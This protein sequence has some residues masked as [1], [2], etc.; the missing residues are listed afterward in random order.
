MKEPR[1]DKHVRL[2]QDIPELDLHRGEVGTV[3][4]TWFAP[5][6]AYEVEFEKHPG[7]SVRALLSE[8]QIQEDQA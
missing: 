4:S 1:V 2:K 6:T 7:Q 8:N 5:A 3:C